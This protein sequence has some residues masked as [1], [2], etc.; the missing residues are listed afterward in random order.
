[1]EGLRILD[2]YCGMGGLSLGFAAALKRYIEEVRGFDINKWAV[3]TYNINLNRFGCRASV[4]NVLRWD[5]DSHYHIIVGGSPCQPFSSATAQEKQ[6]ERHHYFPTLRRYFELVEMIQ[7]E[8]FMMENVPGLITRKHCHYLAQELHHVKN[9]AVRYRVFNAADYGVPQKRTRL[10][11]VGVR[12]DIYEDFDFPERTHSPEGWLTVRDAIQDIMDFPLLNVKDIR[13]EE[14][15]NC[16]YIMNVDGSIREKRLSSFVKQHPPLEL[17]KPSKTLL[18]KPD[19]FTVPFLKY[20]GVTVYRKL[21]VRE[22]LRIQT[23]P[24]WWEYPKP[25]PA[26]ERYKLIG[27]AVPPVLAYRLAE[28]AAKILGLEAEKPSREIFDLPFYNR[29]FIDS[30]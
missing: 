5:P 15:D 20:N 27:E 14:K 22:F 21:S 16:I 11:V 30:C 18:T 29:I 8:L 2:L 13:V 3:W 12:A 28:T 9:Y 7:P 17:D 19:Y 6:G 24:D 26:S 25:C 10:I 1:M 23:F 4:Q